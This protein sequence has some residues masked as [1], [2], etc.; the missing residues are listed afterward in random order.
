MN[1]K[2]IQV[3]GMNHSWG[4]PSR[5]FHH[6]FLL[7]DQDCEYDKYPGIVILTDD[8]LKNTVAIKV[9]N[10]H[11]ELPLLLENNKD[12]NVLYWW[13]EI[14]PSRLEKIFAGITE[15]PVYIG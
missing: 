11:K 9:G 12:K 7:L 10:L 15:H 6:L 3:G 13:L 5:D 1:S 8:S 4:D 2:P 14:D